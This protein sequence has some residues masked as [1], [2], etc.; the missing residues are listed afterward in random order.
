MN[1]AGAASRPPQPANTS[2]SKIALRDC[3]R[4]A[5]IPAFRKPSAREASLC[6]AQALHRCYDF[7]NLFASSAGDYKGKESLDGMVHLIECRRKKSDCR[8][9][10]VDFRFWAERFG[11]CENCG[12]RL[13]SA[14]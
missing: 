1:P 6:I 5:S 11:S 3:R 4:M 14:I 9:Q 12:L 2:A 10:I 13:K 7:R 8:V